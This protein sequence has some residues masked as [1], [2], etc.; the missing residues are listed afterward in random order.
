MLCL[1]R[2]SIEALLNRSDRDLSG[3]LEERPPDSDLLMTMIMLSLTL[4]LFSF[5]LVLFMGVSW[6]M[7]ERF[8]RSFSESLD[9]DVKDRFW[10]RFEE[11]RA[12][13]FLM[14]ISMLLAREELLQ[15][16]QKP[17]TPYINVLYT[18]VC[19]LAFLRC[20]FCRVWGSLACASTRW[21]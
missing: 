17:Q 15:K 13:S 6:R 4:A 2:R 7:T 3:W 5:L 18:S 8:R 1:D 11:A 19:W 16:Q 9:G 12:F 20:S 14:D 21:S 10:M